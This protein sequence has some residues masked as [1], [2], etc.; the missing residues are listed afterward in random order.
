VSDEQD[1]QF[2]LRVG[3]E[4]IRLSAQIPGTPAA[5]L[6]LLPLV[7]SL[8]DLVTQVA[9]REAQALGRQVRCGPGCGACCRQL[10]PVSPPE[11]LAL[12]ETIG[13]LA[14]DHRARVLG[15]F[16]ENR[17]RLARSGLEGRLREALT[18]DDGGRDSRRA[19]GLAYF[20]LS[21][22]CP[23]LE[24]ESCSIHPHRPLACREYLVSSDPIHCARAD[25]ES[26][27]V[28]EMPRRLSVLLARLA[29]SK[30][31][32]QPEWIP[33]TLALDETLFDAETVAEPIG[34]GPRVFEHLITLLAN[35]PL[36]GPRQPSQGDP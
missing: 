18:Q 28:L 11:V 15:R 26:L 16:S 33:L 30:F 22:P 29:A 4:R 36:P 10:V 20:A 27:E 34:P 6:D 7:N 31:P 32:G 24:Q 23:F 14:P 9:T 3:R 12:R 17:E 1:F 21:L 25:A 8:A 5:L 13:G 35:A 2:E 19:L